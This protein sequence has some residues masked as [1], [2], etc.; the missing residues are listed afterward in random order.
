[1]GVLGSLISAEGSATVLGWTT[2]PDP[3]FDVSD[4]IADVPVPGPKT[5]GPSAIVVIVGSPARADG[6]G[7]TPSYGEYLLPVIKR[8]RR[9]I[10]RE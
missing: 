2:V 5:G 8:F 4:D 7:S 1:M 3:E 6:G 10:D 9:T